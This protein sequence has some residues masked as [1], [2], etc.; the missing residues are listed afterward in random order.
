MIIIKILAS[1]IILFGF[2][3]IGIYHS[4][5][6]VYRKNDLLEMKRA[7]LNLI[8]EINFL[9]NIEEAICNLE[10]N[11][12]PEVKLIF[13]T[14]REDISKK[15]GENLTDIWNDALDRGSI[16]TYFTLEDKDK[17]YIIGK[18]IGNFDKE[19]SL[20][21]LN[22]ITDY[23]DSKVGELEQDKIKNMKTYQSM[24]VLSGLAVIVLL[25]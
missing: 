17:L 11:L 7:I 10:D 3:T 9:S 21:S 15:R 24:G 5:K 4:Y 18:I 16:N 14:F 6:P 13:T 25:I 1:I 20:E 12:K 8:S 2:S 22:I 19:F 23:I